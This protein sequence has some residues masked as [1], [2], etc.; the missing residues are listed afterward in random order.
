VLEVGRITKPHGLTGEVIV[1]LVTDRTERV[2]AGSVLHAP[3]GPG[4]MR[5]LRSGPHQGRW[6]VAFEGIGDRSAA[7]AV[8]GLVLYAEALVDPDVLWVHE[9][10][11]STVVDTAGVAHGTIVSVIANPA[12]D[13]LELDTGS[14]V[15]ARFVTEHEAGRVV[16]DAPPGLLDGES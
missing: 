12:S 13:V 6:I 5:I 16:V 4:S 10:I 7:E 1:E 3:D 15:P 8:R 2:T 14:L 11:G 9:L